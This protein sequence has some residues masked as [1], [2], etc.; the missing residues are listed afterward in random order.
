MNSIV[1]IALFASGTA[2]LVGGGTQANGGERADVSSSRCNGSGRRSE[3]QKE[4]TGWDSIRNIESWLN[5]VRNRCLR[6]C[7]TG[8]AC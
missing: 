2:K 1:I 3:S 6:R 7:V 8:D 5:D 4:A